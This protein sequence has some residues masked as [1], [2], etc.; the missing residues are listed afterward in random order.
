MSTPVV[1][2]TL[3][4]PFQDVLKLMHKH[5]FRRLP[6]VD[7]RG[8]LIGIISERDVLYASPSPDTSLRVWELIYLAS[9]LQER[10]IIDDRLHTTTPEL[11]A[12]E[13]A[14]LLSKIQ[15]REI[16][17]RDVITTTPN[18]PIEAAAHLMVENDIRGLPVV[19]EHNCVV[20]VIT[21]TDILKTFVERRREA[22]KVQIGS[23]KVEAC[24]TLDPSTDTP[25][26]NVKEATG[27][28]C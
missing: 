6:V 22:H 12:W 4:T 26:T 23:A 7:V 2:I 3:D 16:M 8:K 15:L 19:D 28:I 18:T 20:G 25:D 10:G 17:T 1:T 11:S 13:L 24:M 5:R 21:E 9:K 27:S 14:Y